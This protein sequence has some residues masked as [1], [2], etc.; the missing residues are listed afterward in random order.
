MAYTQHNTTIV[1]LIKP[2]PFPP[3]DDSFDIINRPYGIST[4]SY[5]HKSLIY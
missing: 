4:N 2:F 3:L 5:R 1:Y